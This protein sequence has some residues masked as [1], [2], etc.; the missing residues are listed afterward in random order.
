MSME[1][2]SLAYRRIPF[3]ALHIR[4]YGGPLPTNE[5]CQRQRT[6]F[7]KHGRYGTCDSPGPPVSIQ[8]LVQR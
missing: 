6:L 7:V 2:Q 1:F 4:P 5:R 3:R 8:K